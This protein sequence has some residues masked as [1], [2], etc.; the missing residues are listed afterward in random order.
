[1]TKVHMTK[2]K[3]IFQSSTCLTFCDEQ[4]DQTPRRCLSQNVKHVAGILQDL[5]QFKK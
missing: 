1:M 2:I 4:V 5:K 3:A